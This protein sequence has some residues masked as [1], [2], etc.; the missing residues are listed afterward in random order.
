[1]DTPGLHI[2]LLIALDMLP[3]MM[4]YEIYDIQFFLNSLSSP[5]PAFNILNYVQFNTSNTRSQN[6]KLCVSYSRT[7]KSRHFYFSCLPKL[8]NQLPTADLINM[9]LNSAM[10]LTKEIFSQHFI[11]HFNS[12]HSIFTAHVT[13]IMV[14]YQMISNYY[15]FFQFL[16]L[17]LYLS[18]SFY[19]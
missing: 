16:Y 11:N 5:T 9:S 1:M 2:R 15:L 13:L 17:Y 12:A 4:Y 19:M 18:L 8:W 10:S 6:H 14:T 3:L 7:N